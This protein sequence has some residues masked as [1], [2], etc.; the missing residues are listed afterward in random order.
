MKKF[1]KNVVVVAGIVTA[2][3]PALAAAINKDPVAGLPCEDLV[4]GA[5]PVPVCNS[6]VTTPSGVDM[7][8][9]TNQKDC[10]MVSVANDGDITIDLPARKP[11]KIASVMIQYAYTENITVDNILNSTVALS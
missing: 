3:F 1:L 11:R 5:T 10:A 4:Q 7:T 8:I 2:L 9:S 6:C